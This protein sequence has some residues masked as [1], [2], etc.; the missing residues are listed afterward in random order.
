MHKPARYEYQ[1]FVRIAFNYDFRAIR[2][3]LPNVKD[4]GPMTSSKKWN[5]A[6]LDEMRMV[7]DTDAD[8]IVKDLVASGKVESANYLM[9]T[10]VRYDAPPPEGLP[11]E[12]IT[13]L[14]TTGNVSE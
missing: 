7:G 6:L 1:R 2:F 4:K 10:L 13:Y 12:L 8:E 9:R 11:H 14:N 3:A 5:D